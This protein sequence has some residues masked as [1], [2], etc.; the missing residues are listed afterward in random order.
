MSEI[1]TNLFVYGT[2][3]PGGSNYRQIESL[4][5]DHKPGTIDG[6]LVDLGAYPALLAGYG[7]VRGILLRMKPEGLTIAD[8]IE[9][10]HPDRDR[11]LYVREEVAV[12][13]EGGQDVVAWTYFYADPDAAV[14][15]P[16]LV[17]GE[18]DEMPVFAWRG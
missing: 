11:C 5:I 16:R 17:V 13:V 8:R 18:E 12:R 15:C 9:G 3:M 10:N 7:I 2:L 4:V 1:V 6:V 14:D